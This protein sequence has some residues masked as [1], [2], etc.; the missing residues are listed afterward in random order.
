M[1]SVRLLVWP[2]ILLAFAWP[3]GLSHSAK[4]DAA[5]AGMAMSDCPFHAPPP[6]PCPDEGTAKHAAGT[7]CA[8]MAGM[9]ALMP[10]TPEYVACPREH[11]YVPFV[12]S[13]QTGLLLTKDPPPP[14]A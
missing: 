13:R 1:A 5:T 2:I 9:A 12:E 6:H 7:C 8:M 14:R 10:A 11:D 4:S 3:A